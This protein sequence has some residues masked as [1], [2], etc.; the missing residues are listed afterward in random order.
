MV[1]PS[2]PFVV[3]ARAA[4]ALNGDRPTPARDARR[5]TSGLGCSRSRAYVLWGFLPALL[6]AAAAGRPV[7]IVACRILLVARLL[8]DPAHRHA[9][10]ARRS[11]P[12]PRSRGVL[13]IMA[14]AG[15]LIYVNWQVYVFAIAHRPRRRGALG[16]FIN[17]IVTVLLGVVVLRE[18]LRPAQW[19]AIGI[20]A[21]RDPGAS[22]SATARSRGSRSPWR[23][24][25]GLYGFV[26]KRVGAQVDAVSGLT[27]ETAL[28]RAGRDR[29]AHRRRAS[30]A[31]LVIGTSGTVH[32]AAA[33]SSPASSPRCPLLLFAAAARRLPL[34]YI[35]LHPVPRARSCSSS[36][37]S[38][39]CTRTMPL[40]RWIGFALVWVAL[41]VLTV[42][43]LRSGRAQ[44][45]APPSN[46]SDAGRV[47][48]SPAVRPREGPRMP[49]RARSHRVLVLALAASS[50]AAT[51]A[52]PRRC[53]RP[54][55]P[56]PTPPPATG[57]CASARC[58]RTTGA[59]DL[60]G[61]AQAAGV[62]AAVREINA[63]GGVNGAPGRGGHPER[64]RRDDRDGRDGVRRPRRARRR[65][66]HRPVV[67]G[68]R[69]TSAAAGGRGR[70]PADL[71]G[72]HLPAAD[73]RSTTGAVL[74]HRP[75]AT[76]TRASLLGALRR[77]DGGRRSRCRRTGDELSRDASPRRLETALD[78]QDG[79]LVATAE[80]A[81]AAD[82]AA[83]VAAV[84]AAAG[85][86][87]ARH[88]DDGDADA[89][90]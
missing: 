6:P 34:V 7:E 39:C 22:R 71:A 49:R 8:R 87:G 30:T 90:A 72:R 32:T 35:G 25:F 86:R 77:G 31:G 51:G 76:R 83:V 88:P 64:G 15:V 69:R 53:R 66:R 3:C 60:G 17:P 48:V 46:R 43:M 56:P 75:A 4:L 42:D 52:R 24:S 54:R 73:R 41:I 2:G 21:A 1:L 65:R 85:C 5:R 82:V 50:P 89:A 45:V 27:L 10:L 11:S 70:H 20:S 47:A 13:G 19:V 62:N 26:K 18:R 61:A 28:A 58:F 44:P 37:A 81:V 67:V 68:G 78:A 55:R 23:F 12:S 16:Y 36:S 14:L 9:R 84:A 29:A 59:S 33:C 57:C 74:A 63:A 38:S 80:A 79:E 40:E